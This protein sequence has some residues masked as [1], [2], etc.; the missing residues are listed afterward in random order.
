MDSI[1]LAEKL[2]AKGWWDE[3]ESALQNPGVDSSNRLL[4]SYALTSRK[5]CVEWFTSNNTG[6][7]SVQDLYLQMVDLFDLYT[8][9]WV[10]NNYVGE[11]SISWQR[12]EKANGLTD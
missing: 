1:N 9:R 8:A 6:H 5:E 3:A 11:G 2:M 12:N 4:E 10:L 7:S